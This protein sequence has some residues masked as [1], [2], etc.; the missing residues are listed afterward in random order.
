MNKKRLFLIL[1]GVVTV[2]VAAF[3]TFQVIQSNN[4]TMTLDDQLEQAKVLLDQDQIEESINLFEKVLD[5]DPSHTEA[6]IGLANA[7]M[8]LS[9][10][11][12]AIELLN[13]G[14]SIKPKETQFYYFLSI[15]YEGTNDLENVANTIQAGIKATN[16]EALKELEE[17]LVSNVQIEVDRH[18][19]QQNF[20]KDLSLIWKKNNGVKLPVE[21]EWKLENEDAGSFSDETD[22]S[23]TF[24]GTDVGSVM[25]STTVGSITKETKIFVEEQVIEEITFEPA[26]LEPLAIGQELALSVSGVDAAG[27][28]MEFNPEWTASKDIIEFEKIEG[29]N[30]SI[31][32]IEEGITMVNV[33][34]QELDAELSVAVSDEDKIIETGVLGN[35]TVSISPEQ[36]S[37]PVGTEIQIEAHPVEGWEFVGW[38]GDLTGE[39]N[40]ETVVVEGDMTIQ[41]V[42][43]QS[44]TH[45][46]TLA[47]E[48]EGNIHRESLDTTYNHMDS[49]T[50]TA[51][52]SSGWSFDHWEGS[53]NG[54]NEQIT[55]QM[56]EDKNITAVFTKNHETDES[57]DPADDSPEEKN[58]TTPEKPDPNPNL[59]P[60]E[61]DTEKRP[62]PIYYSLGVNMSGSGT[63]SKSQ[64][65]NSF[66]K[67]TV[68]Q[69]TATPSDG[70][71]FAGW[72]GDASGTSS[73][74]SVTMNSNK[75]VRAVFEQIP[76]T[77]YT[78]S[79][80]VKGEGTI[81]PANGT[82]SE[83]ANVTI[84]AKPAT[85]WEFSHWTGDLTGSYVIENLTMNRDMHV[86]AVFVKIPEE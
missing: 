46:L 2:A 50:L 55:V 82:Y 71:K 57:E 7:N 13:E 63:I 11:D 68:V 84:E 39:T 28:E 36:A 3:F 38:N 47:I 85:G 77:K 65:G 58:P 33:N 60:E 49:V 54:T 10:Y 5:Q 27:E 32:A 80:S 29:Q 18:Y 79:S 41:A 22:T 66:A 30:N 6:R 20:S 73:T 23:V 51:A 9:K 37:Y 74:I 62:D 21:A 70:W 15:A 75:N 59:T 19:V 69:L 86:T 53:V 56:D 35:G 24:T 8:A 81:V 40:P 64:Q 12:V 31:K 17:Q 67:G 61:P 43:E 78:L 45:E 4:I 44:D 26:D 25:L 48:G 72:E 16:N 42:F 83:G 76:E 34:Y 14:I 1:I 52:P